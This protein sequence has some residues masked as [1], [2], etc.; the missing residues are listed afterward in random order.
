MARQAAVYTGTPIYNKYHINGIPVP[1]LCIYLLISMGCN[2]EC[3]KLFPT[4][5]LLNDHNC[6]LQ[7]TS[8]D[9]NIFKF[10]FLQKLNISSLTFSFL[11]WLLYL[12]AVF[13]CKQIFRIN[14]ALHPVHSCS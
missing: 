1:V 12:G 4:E 3:R 7:E 13:Q 14:S 8:S 10:I 2:K 11:N 9:V 6:P 5:A